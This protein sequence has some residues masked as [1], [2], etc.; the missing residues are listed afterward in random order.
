MSMYNIGLSGLM[1]N[2]VAMNVTAQNTANM[3]VSGYTRKVVEQATVV[4]GG[5]GNYGAGDGVTV[6]SIRRVSDQAAIERL[7][8]A[9]QEMQYT[10]TYMVGMQ[11][12]ENVL[13]MEGLNIS[14]GFDEFFATLD[15][16][17]LSPESLVYRNQILATAG[18]LA[19]RFN[20]TMSQI[21]NELSTLM[22]TQNQTIE[23]LNS[24]LDNIAKLN[25]QI[26]KASG[27]GQD[28]ASLQD[29]LDLQLNEI[30]K[31]IGVNVLTKED[32]TVELSTKSGQPLISGQSVAQISINDATGGAY[33]TDLVLTFNGQSV[34]LNDPKGGELGAIADLKNDQYFPIMEDI[35]NIAAGFADA[36]NAI[37]T[38]AGA[39]DLNGNAGQ[40]LFTY[41]PDN[42]ASSLSLTGITAEELAL[43]GTGSIGDGSFATALADLANQPISIG[44]SNI[45][46]YDAYAKIN[47]YVGVATQQAQNNFNTASISI[48][49]AK[50]ARDS[51]SAVSSDEEAANL[52]MYMNAYQANMKVISTASQMF[53]TV[54]NSF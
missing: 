44:G 31:S 30:S 15:E 51:I 34:A 22:R 3:T 52:M 42:P 33:N 32:G 40:A 7:R 39:T 2:Q 8:T 12:I 14:T 23:S 29:A 36:V 20:G 35:N 11:G 17:T 38:S 10:Q 24:Q 50:T 48:S 1:T 18:S 27:S 5:A 25:E 28:I 45:N 49:E 13:G 26:R 6:A 9:G 41:D 46:V 53:D 47:G 37:L 19:S 54:L 4:Y 21:E 43:S 16:A